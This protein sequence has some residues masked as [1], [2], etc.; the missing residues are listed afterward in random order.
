MIE[1]ELTQEYLALGEEIVGIIN[2]HHLT[3]FTAEAVK[4]L[5]TGVNKDIAQVWQALKSLLENPNYD[6]GRSLASDI[7]KI[8]DDGDVRKPTYELAFYAWINNML[9]VI[10]ANSEILADGGMTQ[11]EYDQEMKSL[12]DSFVV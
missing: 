12:R 8:R 4:G 9:S 3:H 10:I 7:I 1:S 2:K 11:A 5:I 6:S